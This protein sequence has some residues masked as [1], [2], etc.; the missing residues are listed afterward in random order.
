MF[1]AQWAAVFF[2]AFILLFSTLSLNANLT[3]PDHEVIVVGAGLSG[4]SAAYH[5]RAAFGDYDGVT[6]AKGAEY[7]SHPEPYVKEVYDALGL[8]M[9]IIQDEANTYLHQDAFY[10]GLQQNAEL[11]ISESS[12]E[13]YNQFVNTVEAY[14]A[15]YHDLPHY[16]PGEELSEL[17][18]KTALQWFQD[19]QLP[20]IY[21]NTFSTFT[22]GFYGAGLDEVSALSLL[23]R[24]AENLY[25]TTTRPLYAFTNGMK[26]VVDA[27]IAA[28]GETIHVNST[29][30]TIEK[31]EDSY[32]TVTY[33]DADNHP[34]TVRAKAVIV[35]VPANI[36][37]YIASNLLS[38]RQREILAS[39][40]YANYA[41][42][43]FFLSTSLFD[44]GLQLSVLNPS[45][46]THL[47]HSTWLQTLD[48]DSTP[49]SSASILTALIP[50][51]DNLEK[52]FFEW[53]E[54]E[55]IQACVTDLKQIYPQAEEAIIEAEADFR[56]KTFPIMST[57]AYQRILELHQSTGNG[58]YLT[59]DFMSY[60]SYDASIRTGKY[61]AERALLDMD[62]LSNVS[63]YTHY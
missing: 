25:G 14:M 62:R 55:L 35:A 19:L 23:P 56:T 12:E 9:H 57:G 4:M 43:T 46:F 42:A 30:N 16:Q 60:P 58:F 22:R 13:I 2:T 41:R 50:E 20:D 27:Y 29:V 47:I 48:P 32:F 44:D 59:G 1:K 63:H 53:N 8:S 24:L 45:F 11:L 28:L 54:E 33:T 34:H 5:C 21:I 37:P 7:L 26:D 38:E 49:H 51:N 6:Y 18:Q 31:N 15:G 17:D 39:I 40:K 3:P 10:K 52:P 61:A 36:V